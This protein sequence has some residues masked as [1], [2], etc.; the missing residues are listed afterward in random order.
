MKLYTIQLA[1]W[2]VAKALGIPLVNTTVKSGLQFLAPIWTMVL[3]HKD[4]II[5]DEEYTILY[6]TKMA[7]SLE[8]NPEE[9]GWLLGMEEVAIACYCRH[10]AFCHRMLLVEI[11]KRQCEDRGI[12]FAYMGEIRKGQ[13]EK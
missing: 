7:R 1:Q 13:T 12:E 6:Y 11:I 9:W 5:S 2:N 3:D 4:G 8:N 10:G